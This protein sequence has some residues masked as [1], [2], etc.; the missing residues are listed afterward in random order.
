MGGASPTP[1]LHALAAETDAV[2][3]RDGHYTNGAPEW[4]SQL[5]NV[6]TLVVVSL[7]TLSCVWLIVLAVRSRKYTTAADR[8]PLYL[9][10]S[11]LGWSLPQI[12]GYGF[13]AWNHYFPPAAACSA[14]G[15]LLM[16]FISWELTMSCVMSIAMT[17]SVLKGRPLDLGTWDSSLVLAAIIESAVWVVSGDPKAVYNVFGTDFYWC[18]FNIHSPYWRIFASVAAGTTT[19]VILIPIVSGAVVYRRLAEIWKQASSQAAWRNSANVALSL[20]AIRAAIVR[21]ILNFELATVITFLPSAAYCITSAAFQTVPY[22]A[23]LVICL[24]N[25]SGGMMLLAAYSLDRRRAG[26]D[27]DGTERRRR[28]RVTVEAP[29]DA[30]AAATAGMPPAAGGWEWWRGV[31]DDVGFGSSGYSSSG[32]SSVGGRLNARS[33]DVLVLAQPL[34]D[35]DK[36]SPPPRLQQWGVRDNPAVVAVDGARPGRAPYAFADGVAVSAR[37]NGWTGPEEHS[38]AARRATDF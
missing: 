7:S 32:S 27:Y 2:F 4:Q 34:R 8:F 14:I 36:R 18:L 15:T 13:M 6:A 23:A 38:Q 16:V 20:Q 30:A 21:R 12:Y 3:D 11:K 24:I 9:A 37:L 31:D 1:L 28:A 25:N 26:D 19:I 22:F 35:P 33:T 10:V 17:V 29:L 5:L